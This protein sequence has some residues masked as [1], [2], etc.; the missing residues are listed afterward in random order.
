MLVDSHC[1]L[2]RLKL[3]RYQGDLDLAIEAASHA[4]VSKILCISIDRNNVNTVVDIARKYPHVFASV[5]IHPLDV[6]DSPAVV[7]ELIA[8]AALD[9]KVVALGETGLDYYYSED[10]IQLQQQSFIAH[11]E[12][13]KICRKP[14]VVHTRQAQKDT[15]DILKNHSDTSVAGVMHCFT[16]DWTMAKQA[17]DL[18][19]YIS[20]SGIVTFKNADQVRDVASKVPLDR[21]LI[22]TDSPYLAPIPYRG[23]PNEPQYV[24]EVAEFVANLRGLSLQEFAALTTENFERFIAI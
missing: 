4:E 23:K 3:D 18:G 7:D 17:L 14:V 6:A 8:M 5:G 21:L 12:A 22:E 20:I 9:K 24:R 19:F 11:L 16:E 15:I 1:H 10:N 2:D 13:A